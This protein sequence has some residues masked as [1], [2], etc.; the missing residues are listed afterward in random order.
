M[1][2]IA[3]QTN[4][5]QFSLK[6][7][8]STISRNY[9][10]ILQSIGGGQQDF[11][12]GSIKRAVFLLS[13]PMI[14]EMTMESIF[15]L[16]DIYFI[17]RLGTDEVAIVGVT[18]SFLTIV[19]SLGIG[20]S[21]ATTA[22]VARRIGEKDKK[23]ASLTA[24]QAIVGGLCLSIII[25]FIGIFYSNELL[26]LMGINE[27]IAVNMSGYTSMM[28]AGNAT[29]ML[30]FI[31]NAVF[32]SAGD[33][34]ISFIVLAF[35]NIINI[36]LDP[37]LIFG[38][39]PFPELGLNGA[40]IA[41]NIGRGLAVLFQFYLLFKGTHNIKLHWNKLKIEIYVMIKLLKLSLGGM[42]QMLIATSSWIILVRIISEFGNEVIAGYTLAIRVI[43][44]AILPSIGI[45]NASATLVGQNLGAN[46]PDRAEKSAWLVTKI[47]MIFMGGIG[48]LLFIFSDSIIGFF[49]PTADALSS[50]SQCLKIISIGL[51]IY[52][53]GMV[54]V[55]SLNG[56][57][58]TSTPT[59][60]NLIGF[61]LLEIPLAYILAIKLKMEENGVFF[62]IVIADIAIT[63]M[64][65][66]VF[67]RGKWKLKKV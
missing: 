22:M 6:T 60:I 41:T 12:K 31:I 61:W 56:A 35:A 64:A 40:A 3:K 50:G 37:C 67:K 14:L 9:N 17:S 62:S 65:F 30:L 34:L 63:I 43:I 32:R 15:A 10:T 8:T 27:S 26:M 58:D 51:F 25:M 55:H 49:K 57:G 42:S 24:F 18:E 47:N 4:I 16:V 48:I 13:I 11:T 2:K 53:I 1:R 39:G 23:G 52:G 33:A 44:F 21:M 28:L 59:K 19:Y 46:N 7:F 20:L 66:I 36:I 45:S 29:I 54:L 5:L 38:L